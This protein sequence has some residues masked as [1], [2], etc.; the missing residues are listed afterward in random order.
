MRFQHRDAH[1]I[2][3]EPEG[4]NDDTIYPNGISTSLSEEVQKTFLKTIPGLE[5]TRIIQPG[6]AIEYDYVDPRE[7]KPSLETRAVNGLFLAG[8]ING[9]TGYEEAAAQGLIAGLNAVLS[10]NEEPS[11]FTISRTDGYI[12]VMIDDLISRGVQEPYR[13]FTSRAEY[14]LR[15]RADN[16]DQR[17]T[18]LGLALGCVGSGRERVFKEKAQIL[19]TSEALLKE[20]SLTPSE[21]GNHGLRLNQDGRRR[22]AYDL[23][24]LAEIELADLAK[25]L[26]A[27]GRHTRTHCQ[28]AQSGFQIFRL[29]GA[30]GSRYKSLQAG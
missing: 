26:A 18:P 15:L 24:S 2:F 22:S 17:L 3:L 25:N 6:Y 20:L 13:M 30:S 11:T 14:R 16:A 7:L 5:N 1:Q 23:L 12:G 19:S 29:S 4:L 21:A 10:L 27:A 28:S 9:T 8:Q